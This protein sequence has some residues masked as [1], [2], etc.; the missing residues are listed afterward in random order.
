MLGGVEGSRNVKRYDAHLHEC[1]QFIE[2]SV[3]CRQQCVHVLTAMCA[4]RADLAKTCTGILAI[5]NLFEFGQLRCSQ[6]MLI[7]SNEL[8]FEDVS[9]PDFGSGIIPA[10]FPTVRIYSRS[11][12]ISEN[13]T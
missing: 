4:T 8:L 7:I 13:F 1:I 5:I 12:N 10:L 6:T 11:Q 9:D 2:T 3:L